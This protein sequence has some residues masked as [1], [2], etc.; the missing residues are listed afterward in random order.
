MMPLMSVLVV[1]GGFMGFNLDEASSWTT[2]FRLIGFLVIGIGVAGF[3]L[4]RE[5][6]VE[7]GENQDYFANR[8]AQ[9]WWSL[10]KRFQRTFRWVV[11]GI[12]CAPDDIISL[13]SKNPDLMKLVAQLSQPVYRTNEVGK[14]VVD[15]AAL[16]KI[17]EVFA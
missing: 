5:P 3:F 16:S 14:M 13:S 17:E 7:T 8:K 4:I 6:K 11:G 2:I 10:R 9:G 12:P 15:K 1:F